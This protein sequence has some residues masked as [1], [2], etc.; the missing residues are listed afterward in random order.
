MPIR[1]CATIA[2]FATTPFIA[3][4]T[5]P[6]SM[7]ADNHTNTSSIS[8]A[9]TSSSSPT[10]FVI[11]GSGV[12]TALPQ[13]SCIIR[14]TDYYC[15]PCHDAVKNPSGPNRR[16][17]VSA[18]VRL[19]G[20][21]VLIDCGK[22]IREAA[23]QHFPALGVTEIDAIVLT[24]GHADAILGLDD[25]RD[26]QRN[27]V[28]RNINGKVHRTLQQT[29][30]IFLNEDTMRVCQNVFPYLIPEEQQV[31]TAPKKVKDISRRVAS[32]TWNVYD[33]HKY[34]VPFRPVPEVD[35]EFTPF[36]MLHGGNY[37]CMGFLIKLRENEDASH[38]VIAYLSDVY[39]LPEKTWTFLEEQPCI[40]LLV[41]DL[42]TKSR[43]NKSHFCFEQSIDVV[44]RLRPCRAV[45]V[46]MTCSLG[47]HDEVNAELA[48]Y[49]EEG[50]NFRLAY[51][52][53]RFPC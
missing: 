24:H 33:E 13:I 29:T 41:V 37:V 1:Q 53:M 39:E 46:G 21:T 47:M 23:I 35:I 17:N 38:F 42:L 10:E 20:R 12:S 28:T 32:L 50:L 26:I 30:P 15:R 48:K 22:T 7:S 16:G 49:D 19:R 27:A 34:L 31:H 43:R 51:D 40:D 5:A 36:P 14:P 3:T 2:A 11:L 25:A 45:A 52:G 9:T 18:L 8:P 6:I 44:R 4:A